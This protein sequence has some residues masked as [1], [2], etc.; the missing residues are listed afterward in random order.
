MD[1]GKGRRRGE[2]ASRAGKGYPYR[3]C[4]PC[5]FTRVSVFLCL[6]SGLP[7]ATDAKMTQNLEWIPPDV[8]LQIHEHRYCKAQAYLFGYTYVSDIEKSGRSVLDTL[9]CRLRRV[10]YWHSVC[11]PYEKARQVQ[12]SRVWIR[13][14]HGHILVQTT[15]RWLW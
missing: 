11:E 8:M 14:N 13:K 10:V 3:K 1:Y 7:M 5:S 12:K 4:R 9:N 15:G 6:P 2:G